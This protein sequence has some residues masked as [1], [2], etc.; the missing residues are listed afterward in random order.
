MA[1]A[2]TAQIT[3]CIW[4][5]SGHVLL[6]NSSGQKQGIL[7]F[8][9][10]AS[11]QELH[12]KGLRSE[13]HWSYWCAVVV[14]LAGKDFS[15]DSSSD[16]EINLTDGSF[17]GIILHQ[18]FELQTVPALKQARSAYTDTATVGKALHWAGHNCGCLDQ[19]LS[20]GE[21]AWSY[22]DFCSSQWLFDF[23]RATWGYKDRAWSLGQIGW[24]H[25]WSEALWV[26]WEGAFWPFVFMC[27]PPS[28]GSSRC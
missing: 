25:R 20:Q 4:L 3:G 15:Q 12:V 9:L 1:V 27:L 13:I 10:R 7:L 28:R 6:R 2:N 17:L 21:L 24:I 19:P 5:S 11:V 23:F 8:H 18:T 14:G 16:I 22:G 26:A